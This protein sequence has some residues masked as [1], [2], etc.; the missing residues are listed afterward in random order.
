MRLKI[1][2]SQSY[3]HTHIHFSGSK[4]FIIKSSLTTTVPSFQSFSVSS[5][6]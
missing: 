6:R 1:F 3:L 5:N 4:Y 2:K